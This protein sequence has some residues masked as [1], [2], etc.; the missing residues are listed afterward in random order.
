MV[1]ILGNLPTLSGW[2]CLCINWW[3]IFTIMLHF[4]EYSL[5]YGMNGMCDLGRTAMRRSGYGWGEMWFIVSLIRS[6][7]VG[8]KM[9][10][11][12]K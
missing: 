3:Q 2:L 5:W 11:G 12:M 8:D 1:C 9:I 4:E 7:R 6:W 10:N